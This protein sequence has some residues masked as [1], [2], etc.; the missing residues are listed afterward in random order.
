MEKYLINAFSGWSFDYLHC[1]A[2]FLMI[3]MCIGMILLSHACKFFKCSVNFTVITLVL[4][5]AITPTVVDC[6]PKNV[7][8][9]GRQIIVFAQHILVFFPWIPDEDNG[10]DLDTLSI[11]TS[12]VSVLN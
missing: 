5:S 1:Y 8:K 2:Y 9:F 10:I 6:H 12:H 3:F 7:F 11:K 4:P